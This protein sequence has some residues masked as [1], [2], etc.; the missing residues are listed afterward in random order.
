MQGAAWSAFRSPGPWVKIPAPGARS[1]NATWRLVCPRGVVGGVDARASE[2]AVAVEFPGRIGSPV[3]PGITT[4]RSL[5]FTGTYAGRVSHSTAY[6]PFI[7]CIPGGGGGPR[8]PTALTRVSAVKPGEP[9]TVRVATLNVQPGQL[10]RTTLSCR[11]ASACCAAATASASTPRPCRRSSQLAAIRVVRVTRGQQVLVSATRRAGCPPACGPRSRCRRSVR[12]EDR[13][14]ARAPRASDRAARGAGLPRA[15]AAA[16]PLRR[17]LHEHR[18]ARRSRGGQVALAPYLPPALA[19]LALIF[20]VIALARPEIQR[21][22]ANEEASI[23]LTVDVSGSM[24]ADDIKPTRL[25]AAQEAIKSFLDQVPDK[26][27]VGL[28][29]F[30]SEPF[31]ASPL[32]HDHHLVLDVAPVRHGVRPGHCDRRRARPLGRAARTP[33]VPTA[34]APRRRPRRHRR[35]RPIRMR[36]PRRSSCCPT[37]PRRAARS[38]RSTARRVRSRTASRSTRSH[39]APRAARSISAGSRVPCRPIPPRSGR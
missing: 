21:I 34:T 13:V 20:A 8:T 36:R 39:S 10:A 9:I 28:V 19:A 6:R 22:V 33:S 37:A 2:L 35:L 25:V 1:A 26:Y 32:T 12:S 30:S 18:G 17:P 27:R 38:P 31:V 24:Q 29:T 14:A 11:P 15:R 7:G 4:T 16:R 3:N 5:V 23:A